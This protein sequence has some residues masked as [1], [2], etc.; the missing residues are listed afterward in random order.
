MLK[1]R[2]SLEEY[3][4]THDEVFNSGDTLEDRLEYLNNIDKDG[5]LAYE[6]DYQNLVYELKEDDTEDNLGEETERIAARKQPNF[7]SFNNFMIAL[8]KDYSDLPENIKR[9]NEGSTLR[10]THSPIE[11][12]FQSEEIEE[13]DRSET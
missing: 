2:L 12:E 6:W 13:V 10:V 11:Y 9:M 4:R 5:R 3:W 8:N 7:E 1:E